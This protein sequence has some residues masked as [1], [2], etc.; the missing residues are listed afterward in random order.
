MVICNEFLLNVLVL[1]N[2]RH[3]GNC[4]CSVCRNRRLQDILNDGLTNNQLYDLFLI[5][6]LSQTVQLKAG[7]T[8]HINGCQQTFKGTLVKQ[9]SYLYHFRPFLWAKTFTK[10]QP[11][12]K[13]WF[14][15]KKSKFRKKWFLGNFHPEKG[16]V[17]P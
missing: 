12:V 7:T 15:P 17:P 9:K 16:I 8:L 5:A 13:Y 14:A 10:Y 6:L 1:V 4:F 11:W 3:A 2:G